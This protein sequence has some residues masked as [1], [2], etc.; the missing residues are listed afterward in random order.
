MKRTHRQ[1][2]RIPLKKSETISELWL[3]VD[4]ESS[5]TPWAVV[6]AALIHVSVSLNSS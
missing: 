4:G 6:H 5:S 3:V 1:C 2:E